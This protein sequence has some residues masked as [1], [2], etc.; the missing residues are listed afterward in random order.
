MAVSRKLL[1]EG[2]HEIFSV[3]THVKALLLPA[4]VL[5]VTCLAAASHGASSRTATRAAT[6]ATRRWSSPCW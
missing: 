1:T 3:R 4:L 5:L 6:S 2:E